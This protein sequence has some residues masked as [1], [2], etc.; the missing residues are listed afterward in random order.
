MYNGAQGKT[1][2][3]MTQNL[4]FTGISPTVDALAKA[5]S[6]LVTPILVS[7]DIQMATGI[8]VN[9]LYNV[10]QVWAYEAQQQ[11]LTD[12]QM[13]NFSKPKSSARTINNYV[14]NITFDKITDLVQPEWINSNTSVILVNGVYMNGPWQYPFDEDVE[15]NVAFR[16][17]LKSCFLPSSTVDLMHV[18]VRN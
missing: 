1:Q 9:D 4:N 2:Q 3:V 17:D 11:F 10:H 13:L 18:Q 16:N 5:F 12:V 8:Y 14:Q 7:Y 15:M 6:K